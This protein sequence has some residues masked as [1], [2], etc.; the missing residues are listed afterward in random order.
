MGRA[1]SHITLEC[2]LETH[3]NI[4]II[5]EEVPLIIFLQLNSIY[6]SLLYNLTEHSN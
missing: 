1:A 6:F 3:P 2:A 4:A 5:G